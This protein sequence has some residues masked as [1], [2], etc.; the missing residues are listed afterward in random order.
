MSLKGQKIGFL[1]GGAM[2]EA[3][4]T[5][6]L[7]AGLVAPS[8]LFVSVFSTRRS[9]HLK[10]KLGVN[11]TTNNTA[12]VREADIVVLAVKPQIMTSVL[13]E[14]APLVRPE[15]TLISIAAG[16]TTEFIE[17]FLN[18]SIPVVRVMPNT[19]CMVGEGASAISAGKHAGRESKLCSA[20]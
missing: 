4:I 8:D 6:L 2:G 18:G 19:P 7:R 10:Q 13:K 1:G 5:G 14:I 11:A 17:S 20:F 12:V 3:I 9:E 15:Q 16:I